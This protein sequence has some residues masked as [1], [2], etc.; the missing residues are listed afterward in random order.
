MFVSGNIFVS[1]YICQ[2]VYVHVSAS[3]CVGICEWQN[4]RTFREHV[5]QMSANVTCLGLRNCYLD[6]PPAP[7]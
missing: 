6:P 4:H 1:G 3:M 7:L 2:C 5:T